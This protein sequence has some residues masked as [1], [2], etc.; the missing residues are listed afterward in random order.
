MPM[1]EKTN[2]VGARLPGKIHSWLRKKVEDKEYPN[3]SQAIIGEL[4]IAQNF[5]KTADIMIGD[6]LAD[7]IIERMKNNRD[8]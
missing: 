1:K 4:T 5:E 3:M 6:Q 8:K 7:R 2:Y